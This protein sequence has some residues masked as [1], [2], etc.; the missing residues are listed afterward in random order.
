ME[1]RLIQSTIGNF[2]MMDTREQSLV[3]KI[4]IYDNNE[5]LK[6]DGQKCLIYVSDKDE[7][8]STQNE[9]EGYW[10]QWNIDAIIEAGFNYA[11]H[12]WFSTTDYRKQCMAFSRVFIENYK[13]INQNMIKDESDRIQK[14]IQQLQDKMES[15]RV[16]NS[17]IEVA[18]LMLQQIEKKPDLKTFLPA[19]CP[20]C[21]EHK[22]NDERVKNGMECAACAGLKGEE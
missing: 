19:I 16:P 22:P 21:L 13:E 14:K 11:N 15:L 8:D 9:L 18:E 20:E 7:P 2:N 4:G 17:T 12:I 6:Y 10:E 5:L 3:F 1:I